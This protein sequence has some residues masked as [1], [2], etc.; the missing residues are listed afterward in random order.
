MEEIVKKG[1]WA[2]QSGVNKFLIVASIVGIVVGVTLYNNR[3][4][5]D[6]EGKANDPNNNGS[7]TQENTSHSSDSKGD[8]DSATNESFQSEINI[9]DL[10]NN[11]QGCSMV[12]ANFGRD[13]DYVKCDGKWYGK[14]KLNPSNPSFKDAFPKWTDLS[15]KAV[16]VERL[17]RRFPDM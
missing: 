9:Q 11:G 14:A 3:Q 1:W 6:D 10:P 2:R 16:I 17:N 12:I 4:D 5:D 13:L 7:N 15:E 8:L